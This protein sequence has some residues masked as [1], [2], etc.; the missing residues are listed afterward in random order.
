MSMAATAVQPIRPEDLEDPKEYEK[1]RRGRLVAMVRYKNTRRLALADDVSLLFED[2]K[3]IQHQIQEMIRLEGDD[4]DAVRGVFRHYDDL[5]P[6]GKDLIGT[7][8]V[9]VKE[10]SEIKPRLRLY[11]RLPEALQVR[12]GDV[13]VRPKLLGESGDD[14]AATA[15]TFLRFPIP[16]GARDR[17]EKA[18]I[19]VDHPHLEGA[20]PLPEGVRSVPQ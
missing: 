16:D 11:A 18:E 14:D 20:F 19:V 8:F 3:T 5:M 1:E 10:S 17:L 2:R 4:E 13:T 12:I 15:V 9:E 6:N 7:L